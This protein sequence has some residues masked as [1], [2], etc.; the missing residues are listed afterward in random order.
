ML[1]TTSCILEKYS[2]YPHGPPER[3]QY[4]SNVNKANLTLVHFKEVLTKVIDF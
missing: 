4:R 3:S 2:L 1:R